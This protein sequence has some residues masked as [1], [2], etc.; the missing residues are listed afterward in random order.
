MGPRMSRAILRHETGSFGPDD[1][2][3]A[4]HRGANIAPQPCMR[5][6]LPRIRTMMQPCA[7]VGEAPGGG[8]ILFAGAPV[9][10]IGS[11]GPPPPPDRHRR[12]I[13]GS[14]ERAETP[15]L[16]ARQVRGRAVACSLPV[17][18]A[19]IAMPPSSRSRTTAW[20]M[21]VRHDGVRGGLRYP[22][23]VRAEREPGG[24]SLVS[25]PA[26]SAPLARGLAWFSCCACCRTPIRRL[27]RMHSYA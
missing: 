16:D 27:R 3:G 8:A 4:R 10:P 18:V 19:S 12:L 24:L 17:W 1:Q 2:N 20:I 26:F 6:I 23:A 5:R 11:V 25:R 9:G 14:G 21:G 7:S 22:S 15:G 13:R